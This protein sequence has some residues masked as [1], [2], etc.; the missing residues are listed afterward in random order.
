MTLRK[1]H[2]GHHQQQQ[3]LNLFNNIETFPKERDSE[4]KMNAANSMKFGDNH[5]SFHHVQK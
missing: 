3:N 2:Q 1:L 4:N 5:Y